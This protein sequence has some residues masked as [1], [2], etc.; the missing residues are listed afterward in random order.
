M[1]EV[2]T[3]KL[4]D[5]LAI[6]DFQVRLAR[7]TE[8]IELDLSV[9]GKGVKAV[10]DDPSRGGYW[11]ATVDNV[12]VGC[13]LT[14][15]EWSDW[16]NGTVLWI[17]SVYVVLEVRRQGVFRAMFDRLQKEVETSE[18]LRGL[19]LY[20]EKENERAHD[21]YKALGMSDARYHLFEWMKEGW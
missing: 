3:G 8:H 15:P 6:A 14:V 12:L 19:R 5:A 2:R 16:R 4:E 7:E 1:I 17:H 20:V 9:V 11:V 21:V 10:F 18:D 13:L